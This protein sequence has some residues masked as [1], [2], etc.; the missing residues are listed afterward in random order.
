MSPAKPG[1]KTFEELVA[2]LQEHY[3]PKPS[4]TVQRAKFH[5]RVRKQ[6]ETIADFVVELRALA[7]FCNFGASLNEMLRDRIVC[8][9]NSSKLQQRLLAEKELTLVKAIDLAQGMETATK[10]CHN[11]G[12]K[13]HLNTVCRSQG[14]KR[15]D[16]QVHKMEDDVTESTD[17]EDEYELFAI[18]SSKKTK[19][20]T[21]KLEVDG[22][23]VHMEIDTGAS[24]TLMSEQTF[25]NQWPIATLATSTITLHSY[26]GESI[27]VLGTVDVRVKYGG[28]EVTLP[29]LIVKG[30]GPSLLGRNWLE[31]IKLNW[32]EIVWLQNAA[33]ND[34]LEKH[35]TVFGSDLGTAKAKIIVESNASPRF[36]RARSVPYF[37]QD[38]VETELE[39]LVLEGTLEPVEHS[40][41]AILIVAVLK[42]DKRRVRI[43]GDFKQTVNPVTKLDKYPIPQVEDLFAKLAGG[44][45]FTKLDL[46]QA[47]LQLPLD[48]ESK[49]LLVVNT[50]KVCFAT[51]GCPTEYHQHQEFSRGTWKIYYRESPMLLCT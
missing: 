38:M 39:K 7:E 28:Q 36:L 4:E 29:L 32:Y 50:Q 22:K 26:S 14:P 24:L 33:L 13:G 49:E 15:T 1:D 19:P 45:A 16:R 25:H 20:F 51:L 9:I 46:S 30:E 37:Y 3:N 34:L 5:S 42:P 2:L 6:R 43:C 21:A 11:C 23:P 44:K 27:P 35:R 31:E 8:G 18:N 12:R 17:S 47:Y 40:D 48:E 41:W 10:N